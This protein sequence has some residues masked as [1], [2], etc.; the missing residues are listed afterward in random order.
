MS[1][2]P[3]ANLNAIELTQAELDSVAGGGMA[4]AMGQAAAQAAMSQAV[5]QATKAAAAQAANMASAQ[6]N[7][8]G[9]LNKSAGGAMK[10]T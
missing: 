4:S 6:A 5:A 8:S 10:H 7:R 1:T 3:N 9:T 2:E